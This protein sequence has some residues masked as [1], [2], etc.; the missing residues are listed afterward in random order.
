MDP[1][2]MRGRERGRFRGRFNIDYC[3][4]RAR[5]TSNESIRAQDSLVHVYAFIRIS[6]TIRRK[7]HM[8]RMDTEEDKVIYFLKKKSQ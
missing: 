8:K 6:R 2:W 3:P 7:A 4:M 5:S 1:R